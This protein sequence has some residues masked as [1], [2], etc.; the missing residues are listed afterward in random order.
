MQEGKVNMLP[1]EGV[2]A[3]SASAGSARLGPQ[4]RS[5]FHR[6]FGPEDGP[7]HVKSDLNEFHQCLH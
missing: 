4:P 6:T 5:F 2:M 3:Q 1:E 7:G